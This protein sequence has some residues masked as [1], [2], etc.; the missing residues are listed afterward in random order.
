MFETHQARI[1]ANSM[2]V[3]NLL[4]NKISIDKKSSIIRERAYRWEYILLISI[5]SYGHIF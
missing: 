5:K 4:F 2:Q 3:H 1:K